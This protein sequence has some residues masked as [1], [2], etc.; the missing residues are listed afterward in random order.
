[1]AA[2]PQVGSP[3]IA[4]IEAAVGAAETTEQYPVVRAS[5][6]GRC[7]RAIWYR[8]RWADQPERFEPRILRLFETGHLEEARMVA[9]LQA[10]G[11][12]VQAVDPDTC[13]QWEVVALGGHFKGHTDGEAVGIVEA[14]KTA[15]LLECKTHNAKSFA[16]LVRHGVAVSKPEHVAQMQVYMHLRGLSR[17]FYLAKN[18]DTDELHAERVDYIPTDAVELMAK[19]ERVIRAD[20][21]PARISEDPESFLCRF[22]VSR[23]ICHLGDFALRNCRT[24]LHSS[25]EMDG[26]GRWHCAQHERDLSREDQAAGCS[27]HLYLPDLVPGDQIDADGAAETVTYV[28][29]RGQHS[30]Q[31]WRDAGKAARP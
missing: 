5:M 24:C 27:S 18:K 26:D 14:P 11:V 3:T 16:Q 4:A 8:F 1:M 29:T 20:R 19:A 23:P 30:G 2:L 6:I 17:A 12:A 9:W 13:E 21:A 7:E 22:C 28:L 25:A 15:H 10:A 31:H